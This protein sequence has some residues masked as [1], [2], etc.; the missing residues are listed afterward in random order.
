MCPKPR[1]LAA[2]VAGPHVRGLDGVVLQG[3]QRLEGGH[4]GSRRVGRDFETTAGQGTSLGWRFEQLAAI[5]DGVEDP[6]RLGVCFDTCH[7]FA[8]GYPLGTAKEYRTTMG[9]L[10]KTV[11]AVLDEVK[12]L[13]IGENTF[14][15]AMADNGQSKYVTGLV[16]VAGLRVSTSVTPPAEGDPPGRNTLTTRARS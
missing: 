5:L 2:E 1:L 11:G 15:I 6:D 10:D 13:G 8:A 12:K 9:Q 4:D 7:V 16:S 14:I 3:L